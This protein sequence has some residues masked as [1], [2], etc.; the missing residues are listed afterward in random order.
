MYIIEMGRMSD[1]HSFHWSRRFEQAH[2]TS[3]KRSSK[4]CSFILA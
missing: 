4:L 2:R 1:I 3:A